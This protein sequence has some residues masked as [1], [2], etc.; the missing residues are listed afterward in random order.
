M[1]ILQSDTQPALPSTSFAAVVASRMRL[2]A[3]LDT[4]PPGCDDTTPRLLYF[5]PA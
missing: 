5:T 4:C 1:G 2:S 3:A